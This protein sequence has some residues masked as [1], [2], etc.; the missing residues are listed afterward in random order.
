MLVEQLIILIVLMIFS[1]VR[2]NVLIYIRLD[3]NS[4]TT[5]KFNYSDSYVKLDHVCLK[6]HVGRLRIIKIKICFI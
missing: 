1:V 3:S 2:N 4:T 6:S 5:E